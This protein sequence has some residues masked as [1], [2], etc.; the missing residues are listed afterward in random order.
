MLGPY[1][2]VPQTSQHPKVFGS[3]ILVLTGILPSHLLSPLPSM[4][5]NQDSS[6]FLKKKPKSALQQ[7]TLLGFTSFI[8]MI[9]GKAQQ[10]KKELTYPTKARQHG[11]KN[12]IHSPNWL[13]SVDQL[14]LKMVSVSQRGCCT[15]FKLHKTKLKLFKSPPLNFIA[16]LLFHR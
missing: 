11:H 5:K 10:K 7:K 16:Y 4:M 14:V 2:K 15:C 12:V 8:L 6:I 13:K 1:S 9:K 3:G